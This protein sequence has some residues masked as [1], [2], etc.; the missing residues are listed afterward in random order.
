MTA[1]ELAGDSLSDSR[2][3]VILR[4]LRD[5][6]L[7]FRAQIDGR[8]CRWFTSRAAAEG[9]CRRRAA[10][11]A[12][13]VARG[14]GKDRARAPWPA[15]AQPHTTPETKITIAPPMPRVLRTNTYSQFF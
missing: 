9:I 3:R 10:A 1:A 5:A 6:G 14:S 13:T 12:P 4:E 7:L 8:Q 2:A 11:S 15:D